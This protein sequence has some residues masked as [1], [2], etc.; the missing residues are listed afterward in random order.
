MYNEK[1]KLIQWDAWDNSSQAIFVNAIFKSCNN[2]HKVRVRS[3]YCYRGE[4]GNYV[5]AEYWDSQ[6]V[7]VYS[8]PSTE[9]VDE[10]QIKELNREMRRM[11]SIK[12]GS[13]GLLVVTDATFGDEVIDLSTN[14]HFI[15][16]DINKVLKIVENVIM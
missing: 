8:L 14:S 10:E 16:S 12:I 11:N 6:W 2:L 9:M 15:V 1:F 3:K 13:N 4:Q 5:K 7:N